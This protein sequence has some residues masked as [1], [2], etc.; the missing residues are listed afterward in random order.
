MP[1]LDEEE[2]FSTPVDETKGE[3]L[4]WTLDN[5]HKLDLPCVTL[6]FSLYRAENFY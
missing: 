5:E 4:D 1:I 3:R 2:G 6:E